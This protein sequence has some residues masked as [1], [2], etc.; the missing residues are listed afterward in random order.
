MAKREYM[1]YLLRMWRENKDSAWR[2]LLVNPNNGEQA[3]FAS[4][5]DLVTFLERQTGE[6]I[7]DIDRGGKEKLALSSVEASISTRNTRKSGDKS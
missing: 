4:L 1:A 6:S 5:A 3:G 7:Q 2:A